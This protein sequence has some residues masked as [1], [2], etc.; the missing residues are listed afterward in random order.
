M[1][2]ASGQGPDVEAAV[3]RFRETGVAR[4]TV[5]PYLL[6]PGMFADRIRGSAAAAG[7]RCAEVLSD[8]P[9][10]VDLVL[11]RVRGAAGQGHRPH[12]RAAA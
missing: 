4:V 6:A 1:A 3:A 2:Y 8:H 9:A 5:A 12:P 10:V 11:E 7:A